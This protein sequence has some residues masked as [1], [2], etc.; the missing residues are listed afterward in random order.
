MLNGTKTREGVPRLVERVVCLLDLGGFV[1]HRRALKSVR[2]EKVRMGRPRA[3]L[4]PTIA[5]MR[6]MPDPT[7]CDGHLIGE[8]KHPAG[9]R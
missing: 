5:L 4:S 1:C 7:V 6:G 2:W 3:K 8:S 9:S